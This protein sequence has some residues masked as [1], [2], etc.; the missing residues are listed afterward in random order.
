MGAKWGGRSRQRYRDGEQ[1]LVAGAVPDKQFRRAVV[2]AAHAVPVNKG[3]RVGV[4][5]QR[6]EFG[7]ARRQIHLG[8]GDELLD[9]KRRRKLLKRFIIN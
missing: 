2:R 6:N 7:L 3:E 9:K 1:I 4:G 8:K 5:G